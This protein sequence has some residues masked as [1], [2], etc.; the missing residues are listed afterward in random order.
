MGKAGQRVEVAGGPRYF[1][2]ASQLGEVV[3]RRDK[4]QLP[5]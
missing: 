4:G 3:G 5:L 1:S 2:L